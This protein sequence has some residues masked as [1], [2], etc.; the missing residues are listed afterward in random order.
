MRR[1]IP[2]AAVLLCVSLLARHDVRAQEAPIVSPLA[3]S[4]SQLVSDAGFGETVSVTVVDAASGQTLFSHQSEIALN[5]ASNMKLVTAAAALA[6]LGPEFRMR[7]ALYGRVEGDGVATLS[8]RGFGDPSLTQADLVELARDLAD[9]GVRRVG[10]VVVDATYFEGHL[11]PPAFDQQPGEVA[12]FRAATGAVSV[13]ANAYTLRV[14][15]GA[16][17]GAPARVRLDGAGYFALESTITTSDSGQ[18]SI[19]AIQRDQGEH[20]QLALRGTMPIGVTGVSYRRRIENPL[21]WAGHLTRDALAAAGIRSNDAV[22]IAATP[23]D[24]ALLAQHSSEPLA[25]ILSAMGKQSDN[26]VAEMVFRVLGA[27]RHRPGRVEDSVGAVR[28]VLRDAGVEPDRVQ[29]VNGSGLFDGNRI[30]SGDLA[31]LLSWMYRQ[32][33]LRAEYVAHLAIGGVDGTLAGRLRDLP[34]PRIV[35][36]KTGTLN[37]AIALS[38]YVLGPDPDRAVA[39]SVIVNGAR[40]RHGPARGLCDGVARAIAQQLWA[41]R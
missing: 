34:R 25:E 11:L 5:P 33:G 20:M 6:R 17:V 28:D 16:T 37:D 13:D 12:P 32:P 39:F 27:E 24:A 14:L 41:G 30:A 35:R 19:V 31:R 2:L 1:A 15:P 18:P 4:L 29:I 36:A 8:L 10:E 38:G 23:D 26:F 40:G 7:T 9:H 22:R 21:A 3:T